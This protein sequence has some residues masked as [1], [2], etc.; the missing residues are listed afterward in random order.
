MLDPS[1][2]PL[3]INVERNENEHENE[4]DHEITHISTSRLL[5][6]NLHRPGL[7]MCLLALS[8]GISGL[9]FG[10]DTGVISSTIVGIRSSLGHPLTTLDK[11]LITS[12]TS[13]FALLVSPASGLLAD[14]YGRKSV[15]LVADLAFFIGAL[16]QAF[17][18]SVGVMIIGRS[19]V[20]LAIGAG[21][22]VA[23]LYIT[24]LSPAPFRGSLVIVSI[25]FVTLGQVIAYVIGWLFVEV[26]NAATGWRW[27][28]GLGAVPAIIQSIIM[29]GMPDTPRWLVMRNRSSEARTVMIKVFGS[30]TEVSYLVDLILR[31]IE[32][33]VNELEKAKKGSIGSE[34]ITSWAY[35]LAWLRHTSSELFC[36]DA[37]RKALMIAC[38]LQSFQELCGFNSLMYF[39]ATIFTLLGFESPTFTSL[40]VACTNFIF[41]CL[42]LL[43]VDRIGR[44]R[45]LLYS[46]PFMFIGL[47]LCSAGFS[48]IPDLVSLS[49]PEAKNISGNNMNSLSSPDK[50]ALV[51]LVSI[52][53]FVSSYAV[54]LGTVPWLQSELFPLPVR[55]LGSSISTSTNWATNF[56][57]G[58]TFLPMTEIFTPTGTFIFYSGVCI[59]GWLAIWRL[60]PERNGFGLEDVRVPITE[61]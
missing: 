38:L 16:I 20:G 9:L 61:S 53:I 48:Y 34:V 7:Y 47:L 49:G 24:E 2:E 14:K 51:V 13:F 50:A 52:V 21:S 46:I 58:L 11:S 33:E 36:V 31:D 41:T 39:S 30:G 28:V 32:S 43:L 35:F 54:G 40:S 45:I 27:I 23:P 10:Y 6:K 5:E 17:A 3:I 37:N 25:L 19:V 22:F 60:Y 29:L 18:S 57:V 59:I 56:L 55:A 44:R 4:L 1:S 12:M 8:A 42:S 15:I 26:D